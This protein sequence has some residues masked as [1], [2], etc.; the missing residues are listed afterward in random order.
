MKRLHTVHSG[1][2]KM[3]KIGKCYAT[4]SSF[5]FLVVHKSV[6]K[7]S[8]NGC[9]TQVTDLSANFQANIAYPAKLYNSG[10]PSVCVAL[11]LM[12]KC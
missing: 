1:K 11:P 9:L 6:E 2:V 10:T 3:S 7:K 4:R 5:R 8:A 12:Q